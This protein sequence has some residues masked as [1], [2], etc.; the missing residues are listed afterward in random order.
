MSMK[1]LELKKERA[2]AAELSDR[3]IARAQSANRVF[4]A[5]E[6]T[7]LDTNLTILKGLSQQIDKIA[8]NNTLHGGAYGAPKGM[9]LEPGS[10]GSRASAS[11]FSADEDPRASAFRGQF[12]GWMNN[13]LTALGGGAPQMVATAPDWRHLHRIG[14]GAGLNRYHHADRGSSLPA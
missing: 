3:I 7:I 1:F 4:T 14:N 6:Q 2:E 9:F 12:A 5:E 13:V 10:G 8:E 11:T